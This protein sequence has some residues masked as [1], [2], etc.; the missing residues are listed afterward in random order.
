MLVLMKVWVGVSWGRE[1]VMG[2]G[3]EMLT[4]CDESRWKEE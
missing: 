4:Y 1:L 3:D 2:A